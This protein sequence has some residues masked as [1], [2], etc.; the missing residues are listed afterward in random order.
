MKFL[1]ASIGLWSL[2][3]P[4]WAQDASFLQAEA[5]LPLMQFFSPKEYNGSPSIWWIEQDPRGVLYFATDEG[6]LEYDGVSWQ[7]IMLPNSAAI[8]SIAHDTEGTIFVGAQS[9]IGYLTPDAT[10][11][12]RYVSL[13][14]HIPPDHRILPEVWNTMATSEGVFFQT[15]TRLYRWGRDETMHVWQPDTRF[16]GTTVIRDTLYVQW[17]D[18][19]LMRVEGDT[20]QRVP[21]GEQVNGLYVSFL[22]PYD[23]KRLLICTPREGL[24]LYDGTSVAP[25]PTEIDDYLRARR[26]YHGQVLPDGTIV[27]A[28]SRG[29][30]VW[31]DHTGRMLRILDE[32]TGLGDA[33]VRFV[34]R[35]RQHNLWLGLNNGIMHLSLA[36]RLTAYLN[37]AGTQGEVRAITRHR[38]ILHIATTLGIY[39]LEPDP[40][41]RV[42]AFRPVPGL[43]YDS[44]ALLRRNSTLLGAGGGLVHAIDQ[45]AVRLAY[46]NANG[47]YILALQQAR[48]DANLVWVGQRDGV[49]PL[50]FRE[51][52]W[53]PGYHVEGISGGV[54]TIAETDDRTLWLGMAPSGVVR[55]HFAEGYSASPHLSYFDE[56]QGLPAG[57]VRVFRV[58]DRIV[59]AYA[60]GLLRFDERQNPPFVPETAFGAVLADGSRG[61]LQMAQQADGTVWIVTSEELGLAQRQARGRYRWQSF[62]LSHLRERFIHALFPEV[63]DGRSV[64]WLGTDQGV[65]RYEPS[66]SA[67]G[68]ITFTALIRRVSMGDSLLFGG[69]SLPDDMPPTLAYTRTVLRFAYA[70]PGFDDAG[71]NRY[72]VLLDGFDED[73]S[74]WTAET[75][76]DYTNLPGGDYVF[77]VRARDAYQRISEEA[78]YAFTILPPWYRTWWAY[79]LYL[80]GFVGLIAGIVRWRSAQLAERARRLERLVAER[81]AEVAEKNAQLAQ[82][83]EK[84]RELDEM[85]SRFFANISHELRTPLTLI[86]GP[87]QQAL[88]GTYGTPGTALQPQLTLMQRNGQRLLRLVNQLLDLN[89][90]EAG[91][92]QL[93]AQPHDLVA[94]TRRHIRLFDSLA[95]AKGID[96]SFH[97]DAEPCM[98]PFDAVQFE[99]V[100]ANLLSNAFKFTPEGGTVTVSVGGHQEGVTVIVADTGVGISADKLP[101]VF[102]RFYQ[103]DTS[104]TRKQEGTGIGLALVKE[105]VELHGGTITCSSKVNRGTCF[106]L[107][108]PILDSGFSILDSE[109]DRGG[110]SKAGDSSQ[111]IAEVAVLAEPLTARQDTQSEIDQT[112]VLVVEDN[113]DMRGFLR[114][115]LEAD[116]RVLEAENGQRGLDAA[117]S[118]LPDL[119]VADVMM[120]ELDGFALSRVLKEDPMTDC[121]PVVLL[122]A[123]AETHDELEGLETGADDYVRKPFEAEVLRARVH[124]QIAARQRLRERLRAEAGAAPSDPIP[125]QSAFEQGVRACINAHLDDPGFTVEQLA[126]ELALSHYQLLSRLRDEAGVKPKQL[127]Q[128][129]RLERA[130]EL[131]K[132]RDGTISE[133]AYAVGFNSLS[134]FSYAFRTHFGTA[135]SVYLEAQG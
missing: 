62:P 114:S 78:A 13:I 125:T 20:L 3:V 36:P 42:P 99:K 48:S 38:D 65:L 77:R 83:A 123:R 27:L 24:Y 58:D 81:T 122:T 30:L 96:L 71:Q 67:Q 37:A 68:D 25:F 63:H 86:L 74:G 50:W 117:R 53:V 89:K 17:H 10:G 126:G 7:K 59:F 98:V 79:G 39:R 115:I 72:Q 87:L 127:I 43:I 45:N 9:E 116:Y 100:F 61:V 130:A 29:G 107:R 135:P 80:L 90:L 16:S 19:G 18:R 112:T 92:L 97:A 56:R 119:I 103:V 128:T 111:S 14:D 118:A 51:G 64:V 44:N 35:D 76:K 108:L 70:A 12:L 102:D 82:Q 23:A 124:N 4:V 28:T 34:F 85:K 133:V 46:G 52:H 54:V 101:Y 132:R 91:S 5:G 113:A 129:M 110:A 66:P 134:H 8:R 57:Q 121:I 120:P 95:A 104:S 131:L 40:A 75:Q 33:N 93:D 94:F 88:A 31:L 11:T 49:A 84:L 55:A 21:G 60:G 32:T 1:V 47:E 109:D 106:T 2:A 22:L 15:N 105:L 26:V 69:T 73:W 6:L 41:K